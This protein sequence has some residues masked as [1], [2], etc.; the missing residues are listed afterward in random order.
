LESIDEVLDVNGSETGRGI[1]S[2]GCVKSVRAADDGS[3]TSCATVVLTLG[4]VVEDVVARST[5]VV[6]STGDQTE[7]RFARR[8]TGVVDE[9]EH[10]G[11]N[12]SGAR[13]AGDGVDAA[14]D[15]D[16]VV[17]TEDGDVGIAASCSVVISR[18]WE[19]NSGVHVS[20]DGASLERRLGEDGGESSS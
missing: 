2:G 20:I 12:G 11:K 17:E 19:L 3:T 5:N 18:R 6:Q 8:D 15:D 14:A 4:D 9:R 10:T 1:P 13:S 16:F 7:G